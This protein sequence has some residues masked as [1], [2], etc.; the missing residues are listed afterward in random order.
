MLR[1]PT[2]LRTGWT[3]RSTS[4]EANPCVG[5]LDRQ[6]VGNPVHFGGDLSGP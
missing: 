1:K 4:A 2:E 5:G 3:K 6:I